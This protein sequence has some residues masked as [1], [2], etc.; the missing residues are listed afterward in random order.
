MGC[1]ARFFKKRR[2]AKLASGRILISWTDPSDAIKTTAQIG[3]CLFICLK[4]QFCMRQKRL[5]NPR[6]CAKFIVELKHKRIRNVI[7][8]RK[9]KSTG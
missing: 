2:F 3:R 6:F 8:T 9:T 5:E 1:S 4:G 7:F